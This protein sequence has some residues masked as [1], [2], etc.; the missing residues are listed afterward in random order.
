L[1]SRVEGKRREDKPR[2]PVSLYTRN[3]YPIPNGEK[4]GTWQRK[5]KKKK[6]R[7]D[8]GVTNS[9]RSDPTT[10]GVDGVSSLVHQSYLRGAL[11]LG[12]GSKL[13]G[14]SQLASN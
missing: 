7:R 13:L 9:G 3:Q 11:S 2:L 1:I 12:L 10:I 14:G 6:N 4:E 8:R 5:A